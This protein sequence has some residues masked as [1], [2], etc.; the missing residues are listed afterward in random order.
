VA[1]GAALALVAAAVAVA[2]LRNEA[3]QAVEHLERA[4]EAGEQA[5]R[6]GEQIVANL[7]RIAANLAAAKDLSSHSAEIRA[8]TQK[9]RSSLRQLTGLLKEQLDALRRSARSVGSTAAASAGV[10]GV[11]AEQA[12][13]VAATVRSLRN[14]RADAASAGH[15]SAVL[16]RRATYGARL[17]E[18]SQRTCSNPRFAGARPG[19]GCS[20]LHCLQP[21]WSPRRSS[22]GEAGATPTPRWKERAAS[23]RRASM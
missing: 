18:D 17:A 15:T 22:R 13:L 5:G 7:E 10:A 14:L 1:A 12:R 19:W 8:L 4:T 9:Q 21:G 6:R 11:S 16:A 2:S 3:P 23:M 20:F